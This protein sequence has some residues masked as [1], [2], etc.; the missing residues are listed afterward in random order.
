MRQGRRKG[1]PGAGVE[2][3]PPWYDEY[4]NGK[5]YLLS[6]SLIECKYSGRGDIIPLIAEVRGGSKSVTL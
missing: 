1:W 3:T 5:K 6:I 4:K 2:G